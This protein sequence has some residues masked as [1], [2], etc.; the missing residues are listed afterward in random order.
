MLTATGIGW[1]SQACIESILNFAIGWSLTIQ[2]GPCGV[3]SSVVIPQIVPVHFLKF[4]EHIL[5]LTVSKTNQILLQWDCGTDNY[6]QWYCTVVT[7]ASLQPANPSPVMQHCAVGSQSSWQPQSEGPALQSYKFQS[8]PDMQ[9]KTSAER[10]DMDIHPSLQTA[11]IAD[12]GMENES[13]GSDDNEDPMFYRLLNS[14]IKHRRDYLPM[15]RIRSSPCLSKCMDGESAST[16]GSET[17]GLSEAAGSD[18]V[19]GSNDGSDSS[20]SPYRMRP[21]KK[22]HDEMVSCWGMGMTHSQKI[23]YLSGFKLESFQDVD[24]LTAEKVSYL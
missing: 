22:T 5:H 13:A 17:C 8:L 7:E 15:R 2:Q 9:R 14:S 24:S 19:A 20:W 4:I 11:A 21:L 12:H 23:L 3:R 1:S 16:S 6:Q 10:G 18:D